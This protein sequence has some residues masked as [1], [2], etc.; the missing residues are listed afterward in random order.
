MKPQ[1]FDWRTDAI[2]SYALWAAAK[3]EEGIRA[4]QI[5]PQTA[6]ERRWAAEGPVPVHRMEAGQ[7][8]VTDY[9]G[10]PA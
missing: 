2:R 6:T 9:E 7:I 4:G 10:A 1:P 3:R 8:A 5:D